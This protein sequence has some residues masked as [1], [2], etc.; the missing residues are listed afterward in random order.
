[1]CVR[2]FSNAA[3]G[4]GR[5]VFASERNTRKI[6]QFHAAFLN[7]FSTDLEI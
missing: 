3:K 6:K 5:R 2:I 1:M 7:F 4:A